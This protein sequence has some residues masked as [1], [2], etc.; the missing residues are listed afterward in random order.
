MENNRSIVSDI[1]FSFLLICF[2]PKKRSIE[3][4]PK[5]GLPQDCSCGMLSIFISRVTS[6]SS[7]GTCSRYPSATRWSVLGRH[8]PLCHL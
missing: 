3:S 4:F 8:F 5:R 7:M 1:R 6:I 2:G